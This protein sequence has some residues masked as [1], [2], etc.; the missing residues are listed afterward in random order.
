MATQFEVTPIK[1]YA[2]EKNMLASIRKAFPGID[3]IPV[4]FFTARTEDG[5]VYPVFVGKSAAEY[6]IHFHFNVVA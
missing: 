6:G 2:N 5:R 4:R 1:T 3:R